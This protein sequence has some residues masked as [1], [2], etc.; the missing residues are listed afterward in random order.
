MS[1]AEQDL[2]DPT[3]DELDDVVEAIP[4]APDG[5]VS[6]LPRTR[7]AWRSLLDELGVRPSKGLG[8]NFLFERGIVDRIVRLASVGPDDHVLEVGPG[9]GILT[10]ALIARAGH[11]TAVEYDRRLAAHLR[12]TFDRSGRF[13]L[14]QADALQ[15]P[16]T[17]LFPDDVTFSVVANLPYNIAS[18]VVQHLLEQPHRPTRLTLMVQREVAER[19]VAPPGELSVLGVATQFYAA[20]RILFDIPPTVFVPPPTVTSSVLQL[21]V[22]PELLLADADIPEFMRIVRAGYNQKRKQ[23][24]NSI[25]ARF[26]VPKAGVETWLRSAGVDPDRRA[27]TLTVAEWVA[28]RQAAPGLPAEDTSQSRKRDRVR[29]AADETP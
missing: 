15:T 28:I 25:A 12:W 16:T 23:V 21:D 13:H 14:H 19:I 11:V 10:E 4:A 3:T 7:R 29:P 27:Q 5:F 17:D 1:D 9:L 24:A 6:G 8:Q 26:G 18:A 2:T 20:G 22:R